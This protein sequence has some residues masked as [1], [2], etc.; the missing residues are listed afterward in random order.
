[1]PDMLVKLY[2]LP[3]YKPV[4]EQ[5]KRAG[6]EIRRSIPPEK[7]IVLEWVLDNFYE[8][9][10]P[11]C[12][13]AYSRQPCTC[14]IAI[15]EDEL[16]GFACYDVNAKGIFGPTGVAEAHRGKGTGTALLLACLH[17]MLAQGYAYAIIGRVGPAEFYNK[18][19]GAT[20]IEGSEPGI[21]RGV[22]QRKK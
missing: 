6:I 2:E 1:M 9:W 11:Q 20:L 15:R 7:H 21:F 3:E 5:Q 10:V 19:V 22:L 14:F 17:D 4:A 16:I 12:K 18:V 13:V 8:H